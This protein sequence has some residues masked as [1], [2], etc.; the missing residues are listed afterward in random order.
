[1]QNTYYVF[2]ILKKRVNKC[3]FTQNVI[4]TVALVESRAVLYK[5]TCGLQPNSSN[6]DNVLFL[7][8]QFKIIT[9]IPITHS[10]IFEL[11]WNNLFCIN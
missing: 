9:L 2:F 3:P 8:L 6:L 1:M 7:K 11:V 5:R 10:K 4:H